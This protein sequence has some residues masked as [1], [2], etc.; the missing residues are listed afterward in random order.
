M[1][2]QFETFGAV[3]A[4][5]VG[6]I[7]EGAP[8]AHYRDGADALSLAAGGNLRH[9]ATDSPDSPQHPGRNVRPPHRET[10]LV[11]MHALQH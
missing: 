6:L 10:G 2:E 11:I 1:F 7:P 5:G 8:G 4:L 9:L 3:E